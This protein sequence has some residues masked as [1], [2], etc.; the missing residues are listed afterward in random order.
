[1][2]KNR[3]KKNKENCSFECI[4]SQAKHEFGIKITYGSVQ[5]DTVNVCL[6]QSQ[7]KL[8]PY[9]ARVFFELQH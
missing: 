2:V 1:M 6:W 9:I 8:Y 5:L 3:K 4:H 7:K